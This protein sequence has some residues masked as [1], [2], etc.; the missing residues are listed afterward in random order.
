MLVPGASELSMGHQPN[1]LA[2]NNDRWPISRPQEDQASA[3]ILILAALG[4]I[5]LLIN[6]AG[7]NKMVV[8]PE[9]AATREKAHSA[10]K[11]G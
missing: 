6:F 7:P 3:T 8:F 9:C 5:P 1:I 10:R 2:R 11:G 4:V